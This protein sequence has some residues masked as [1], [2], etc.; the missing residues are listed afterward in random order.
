MRYL[1][2]GAALAALVLLPLSLALELS[3]ALSAVSQ[4]AGVVN[5]AL[6][7]S[8]ARAALA[9]TEADPLALRLERTQ[10]RQRLTLAE[11]QLEQARF[12]ATADIAEAYM[13]ALEAEA[14]LELARF[15]RELA[16]Q[17]LAIARIRFERGSATELEVEEAQN[18]LDDAEQT[19]IVAE[20]GAELARRNLESLIGAPVAELRPISDSYLRPLPRFEVVLAGLERHP[21]LLEAA[22]GV[23]LARL[24]LE[25]L[26]PSY[27]PQV[28]IDAAALQLQQAEALA[29]EARRG[30]ALQAQSLY[31]QARA[32]A[33]SLR[34]R[35]E[36]LR[37]AEARQA[38]E[39]QRLE[40]GLIAEITFKQAQLATKQA[41]LAAVQARHSYLSAL[42]ALQAGTLTPLEGLDGF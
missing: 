33:A 12:T 22:Q 42:L 14:Q 24:G 1:R 16:A 27:A 20:Q 9:R 30:L 15:A 39:A 32:A 2:C 10:A 19:V 23:E 6:A 41:E 26:D 38:L 21:T 18:D 28:Q 11:A 34:V 5:S 31:N 4:R 8:D 40:A 25:L 36:A 3:A 29:A 13:Q 7:A 17:A 37:N 35:Q